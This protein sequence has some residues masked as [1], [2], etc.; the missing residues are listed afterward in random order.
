[1]EDLLDDPDAGI[2]MR[3]FHRNIDQLPHGCALP[4][5]QFHCYRRFPIRRNSL[6]HYRRAMSLERKRRPRA[7]SDAG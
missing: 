1:M 3:H 5:V 7:G 4:W 2:V 6:P